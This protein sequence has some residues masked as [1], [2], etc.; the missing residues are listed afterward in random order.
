MDYTIV[1][2]LCFTKAYK[3]SDSSTLTY[4]QAVATC[5]GP[6]TRLATIRSVAEYD[7]VVR[8]GKMDASESHEMLHFL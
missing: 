7:E 4:A 3:L 8:T 5:A 1:P 6:G 2:G